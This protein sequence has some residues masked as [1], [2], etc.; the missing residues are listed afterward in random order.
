[1]AQIEQLLSDDEVYGQF[2]QKLTQV[3]DKKLD[4]EVDSTFFSD[5]N[6]HTKVSNVY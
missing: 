5:S 4:R 3:L 6:T 1:M 2:V